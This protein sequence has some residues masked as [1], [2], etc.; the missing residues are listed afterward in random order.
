MKKPFELDESSTYRRKLNFLK[1]HREGWLARQ[2]GVCGECKQP[3]EDCE[4]VL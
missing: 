1:M 4:C 2:I 3:L